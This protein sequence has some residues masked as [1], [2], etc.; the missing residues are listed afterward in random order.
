[1]K[2]YYYIT[3]VAIVA[4]VCLQVSYI[5][6]LYN[7]YVDEKIIGIEDIVQ[8]L[9]TRERIIRDALRVGVKPKERPRIMRKHI[10]HM[11]QEEIDSLRRLPGGADT[12]DVI[13]AQKA[14]IGGT[15]GEIVDQLMQDLLL[16]SGFPLNLN[17]L[18]SLWRASDSI[19]RHPHQF[20]LYDKD[21]VMIS[22]V[23]DL[24]SHT[25][26]YVSQLHPIGTKGLQYLQIKAD[27]PMSHFLRHQLWTLALSACMML[28]VLLC[29]FFQLTA[30]RRKEALLRK[31]EMTIN[32]TIHDLKSPL[33]SVITMMGWLKQTAPD[34]ETKE[35]LE[36]SKAGVRRLISNIEALLMT[37][38][39]DRHQV[40]LNK[41]LIDV[42][43]M[44]EG[45]KKELSCLYPGKPHTICI[46][47][48]LPAGLQ[49]MADGM[50]IENVIR[51][52]M[53]NALKYSD[54]GVR[55]EVSL[56]IV[57][58]RLRVSV[59]DNGWGIA[60]CHQKKLFTQFYRVPRSEEQQQKGYGIGLAQSQYIINEHGGEIMV[61]SAEGEGS[62]FTFIIP[63]R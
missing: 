36:T 41:S 5:N 20:F 38:R 19:V 46:I 30:I 56:S 32:G 2:K 8:K 16:K 1:M 29:L 4:T 21:T 17:T 10:S 23:G 51:N 59:K 58:E 39:M 28:L 22:S 7:R 62:T 60:P 45:V 25:P 24:E 26:D 53:E 63:C 50:Y 6:S 47:N 33:N 42:P 54:A 61:K 52:L 11:T 3:L 48:E 40:V 27:I 43:E 35:M 9:S 12:I 18:D 44:A 13:A 49:V 34:K 14:G 57:N 31:R 15:A 55:I 37:A